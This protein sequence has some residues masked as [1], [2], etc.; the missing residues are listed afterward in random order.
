MATDNEKPIPDD[1]QLVSETV[2]MPTTLNHSYSLCSAKLKTQAF[3]PV[4]VNSLLAYLD[5]IHAAIAAHGQPLP[6]IPGVD[7]WTDLSVHHTRVST[8]PDPISPD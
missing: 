2:T 3:L 8:I 4:Y 5:V 6:Y 7:R 1:Q